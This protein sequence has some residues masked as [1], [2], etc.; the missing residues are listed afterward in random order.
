MKWGKFSAS[1][2]PIVTGFDGPPGPDG[3]DGPEG[4]VG[5]PVAFTE[6]EVDL[7]TVAKNAGQFTIAGAGMTPA[8]PVLIFKAVGPYTGKGTLADEAEMDLISVTASVTSATEITAYWQ[9]AGPVS[10]NVKF[11]YVIGI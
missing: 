10:G 3:P 2:V 11:N 8:R 7:G 4:P 5:P 1:G 6:V 9:S